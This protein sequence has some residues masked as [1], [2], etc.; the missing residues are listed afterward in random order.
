MKNAI[1]ERIAACE[2]FRLQYVL[3]A[4][5]G[6][7]LIQCIAFDETG[8]TVSQYCTNAL[9]RNVQ[10]ANALFEVLVENCVFPV[11]IRDII[12]DMANV[13]GENDSFP[14]SA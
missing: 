10:R 1:L 13:N 8:R 9:T 3:L 6:A 11:H 5:N 2:G 14:F 4:E 12:D 7:Y